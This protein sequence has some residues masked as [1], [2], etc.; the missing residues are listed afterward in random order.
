MH[1]YER[2]FHDF[3]TKLVK[4]M[5]AHNYRTS[6]RDT[7]L[8]ILFQLYGSRTGLFEGD[9]FTVGRNDLL[10]PPTFILVEELI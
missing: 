8:S 1:A 9:L 3:I 6:R 4:A 5:Y 2:H 7:V 10:L